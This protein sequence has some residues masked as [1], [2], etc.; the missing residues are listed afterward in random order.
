MP[1]IFQSIDDLD[2]TSLQRV[3][4][5][6]EFRGTYAP[7]VAMREAYLDRLDLP[8]GATVCELGCGTGV[9]SRAIAS[10][11]GFDGRVHATDL[12]EALVSE[13]RRRARLDGIDNVEFHAEPSGHSGKADNSCDLVVLHTLISHVAD[14]ASVL[15]E[16]M[17]IARQSA[18]IVIFDGDYASLTCHAGR[19]ARDAA[20]VET[21]LEAIVANPHIMREIPGMLVDMGVSLEWAQADVL[22]EA[23]EAEF[24]ASL[25]ESYTPMAVRAGLLEASE[26]EDWLHHQRAVSESGRFYGSCNFVSYIARA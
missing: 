23:G 5:R 18:R 2:A 6:L 19:P 24:F 1:D 26:A 21:L 10:R 3:I 17:R 7:F 15:A 4:D 16:A 25:V 9:V 12:S 13:A 14:P 11:A 20:V 8:P 22:M